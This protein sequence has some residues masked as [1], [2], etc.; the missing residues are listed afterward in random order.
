M[1]LLRAPARTLSTARLVRLTVAIAIACLVWQNIHADINSYFQKPQTTTTIHPTA[2]S[3]SVRS[4]TAKNRSTTDELFIEYCNWH[5]D[6]QSAFCGGGICAV[7]DNNA[8]KDC[9]NHWYKYGISERRV[10]PEGL[11]IPAHVLCCHNSFIDNIGHLLTDTLYQAMDCGE[12]IAFK[13]VEGHEHMISQ[14]N[15]TINMALGKVVRPADECEALY[16]R[17]ERIRRSRVC[18]FA[19]FCRDRAGIRYAPI[20]LRKDLRH[21]QSQLLSSCGI[22]TGPQFDESLRP[23]STRVLIIRRAKSRILANVDQ[24]LQA[25]RSLGLDC[26]IFEAASLAS[27]LGGMSNVCAI[28]RQFADALI[29]GVQ[30][31]ELIY[32]YYLGSRHLLGRPSKENYQHP[33]QLASHDRLKGW[34]EVFYPEF[35]LHFGVQ[36][37]YMEGEIVPETL[38]YYNESNQCVVN[39]VF[40]ANLIL[41]PTKVTEY[42]QR[43]LSQGELKDSR[44]NLHAALAVRRGNLQTTKKAEFN[45]AI[46]LNSLEYV[47]APV[48]R[49]ILSNLKSW[50][51]D[52]VDMH[53]GC[54]MWKDPTHPLY[55]DLQLLLSEL[56]VYHER[57]DEF[58]P[59][60]EDIRHLM[61]GHGKKWFSHDVCKKLRLDPAGLKALFPSG[62]LSQVSSG[63]VEPLT[64]PMRHPKFCMDPAT[65]LLDIHYMVHDFEALC[66]KL[67]PSSRTILIDMGASLSFHG[68]KSENPL[69]SLLNLYRRFGFKFDHIYA[70]E[71]EF[72]EPLTV[73]VGNSSV[74]PE[75]MP[76]YHWI[77]VGVT[78]EKGHLLNPLDSI[79]RNFIVEDFVAIKL[80][81]DSPDIEIEL[82]HQLIRDESLSRLVDC[83]YFERHVGLAE[84]RPLGPDWAAAMGTLADMF[85][86]F[87]ALRSRGIAAHFW[88]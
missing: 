52:K 81:I 68:K 43:K 18:A 69:F 41:D 53:Q 10:A 32:T 38:G 14:F 35:A 30:G 88:V 71:K 57:I 54:D 58:S 50:G 8:V 60:E 83:F 1:Q 49:F 29:I 33:I 55:S 51:W 75:Y 27:S 17:M 7:S 70:F 73:F 9:K 36:V 44:G 78:H 65:Y 66:R 56:S 3:S 63:F 20:A 87:F 85:E 16:S 37:T 26:E 74:P 62:Q 67:Q 76:F 6:L 48:E 34:Q 21:A 46:Q 82:V 2:D 79:L 47:P 31:A 28:L 40:C 25:C 72:Y 59:L 77:N 39:P 24:I 4:R 11:E 45:W 64:T 19:F 15:S 5:V 61:F 80:D 22:A 42:L 86:V 23:P 13:N 12:V 84:M